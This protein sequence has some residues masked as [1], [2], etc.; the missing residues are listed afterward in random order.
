MDALDGSKIPRTFQ[1]APTSS[2]PEPV[3]VRQIATED[4]NVIQVHETRTFR[5]EMS[6]SLRVVSE[7][8]WAKDMIQKHHEAIRQ[9][10]QNMRTQ[11]ESLSSITENMMRV[12]STNN[13]RIAQVAQQQLRGAQEAEEQRRQMTDQLN[14]L[15]GKV[16]TI[17]QAPPVEAPPVTPPAASVRPQK[18][19]DLSARRPARRMV[20]PVLPDLPAPEAPEEAPEEVPEPAA[21]G[22]KEDQAAAVE[23]PPKPRGPKHMV[24]T[25]SH[26]STNIP[27]RRALLFTEIRAHTNDSPFT[28]MDLFTS[29]SAFPVGMPGAQQGMP[30]GVPMARAQ[31]GVR[32]EPVAPTDAEDPNAAGGKQV[33]LEPG[34]GDAPATKAVQQEIIQIGRLPQKTLIQNL[35]FDQLSNEMIEDKVALVAR[36]TVTLLA[37]AARNSLM[38]EAQAVQKTV[39]TVLSKMDEKI[40]RDFVERMFNKFRVMI[41][42][43]NEK[44][45][46]VQ[47]SFLE[48]VTRDELELVLQKFVGVVRNVNDAAATKG[49]V[50]CLLCGRPREHLSG[51]SLLQPQHSS[52]R[53]DD[54][55]DR[56][57]KYG[58]KYTDQDPEFHRMDRTGP[59][60]QSIVQFL[61]S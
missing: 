43:I 53:W 35:D 33:I 10:Q 24:F 1:V 40:D 12:N 23:E 27:G 17:E 59:A 13:Q 50:N 5:T 34:R 45:E 2:A 51:I 41:G 47:C 38:S 42:D 7:L 11:E 52:P 26:F 54:G 37:D 9:L 3:P 15:R 30:G 22:A 44:L 55:G 60:P 18:S 46:N 25:I 19:R 16:S 32:A 61:T 56:A 28:T 58:K 48:W 20:L 4:G 31:P 36:K 49:K 39:D 6:T 14:V 29:A 8:E 21:T 57:K